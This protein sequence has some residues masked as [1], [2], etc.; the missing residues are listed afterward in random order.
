LNKKYFNLIDFYG[1]SAIICG[2]LTS[3]FWL[4]HPVDADPTALQNEAFWNAV[5]SSR[6]ILIQ[7]IF[8]IILVFNLFSVIGIKVLLSDRY[9]TL[10]SI[11][12]VLSM[13]GLGMFFGGGAFQAFIVPAIAES[14]SFHPLL[15]PDGPLLGGSLGL[16]LALTGMVFSVGY[17]LFAIAFLR[18]GDFPKYI[19]IL[20]LA[21][22]IL[23]LS[24]LMPLIVRVIGC[25]AYGMA[26]VSIGYQLLRGKQN[27]R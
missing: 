23:G 14:Q 16:Y 26:H 27:T 22:P 24:P 9:Y 5:R 13:T 12:F 18:S 25:A 4:A 7:S 3:F 6:Y 2:V 10:V 21:T 11:G 1:Y 15:D 19:G 17:I 8:I 20:L